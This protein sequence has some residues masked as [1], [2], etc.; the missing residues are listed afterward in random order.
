LALRIK[1]LLLR[2]VP[3]E[4][5][6][7]KILNTQPFGIAKFTKDG[8]Y[9][10][11]NEQEL[12]F[13]NISKEDIKTS[14]IFDFFSQEKREEL[15]DIFHQLIFTPTK[16]S[17]LEYQTDEDYFN[18]RLVKDCDDTIVSTLM[19]ITAQKNIDINLMNER[20][21]IKRLDNA[22]K[23]AKIGVW[24]FLP[25]EGRIL[26]N[27]TWVTQKK[28][29]SEEFRRSDELFSD[30]TDGLKR[31]KSMVHPNDLESTH[32]LIQKHLDGETEVYEAEFRMKCGD[33]KWRWIYDLGRVFQRDE[34]GAAIR[35]NGVH[36]DITKM[37]DLQRELEE[38][39][40]ELEIAKN[41]AE[42][43]ANRDSL[44]GLYNR[45]YFS[46]IAEQNLKTAQRYSHELSVLMI[47]V[48]NF[49]NINDTYGHS[50]GDNVII[51]IAE[52]L[53]E[54]ARDSDIITRYGGEEFVVMLPETSIEDAV[55]AAHRVRVGVEEMLINIENTI[56][57][58]VTVSIGVSNFLAD[59]DLNIDGVM[60]RADDNLYEAKRG[61]KNRVEYS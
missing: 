49:K 44:T 38:K 2:A 28:Y 33:G 1:L 6:Y 14:V 23:G 50:V 52:M 20:E 5:M 54:L 7:E 32:A 36:I 11:F 3:T 46:N 39:R 21:N 31:W 56:R 47:D 17:S 15:K 25:Q 10:Y 59:F 18:M 16:E 55:I 41:R 58:K 24:D 27:E 26:A 42:E 30:V 57:L 4:S 37:K 60:Q 53:K 34:D 40:E 19:N 48:D 45:R 29:K 13:R 8:E 35:M 43:L 12:S 22:L 9:L 51:M 61:G